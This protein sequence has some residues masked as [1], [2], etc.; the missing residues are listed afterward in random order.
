[1]WLDGRAARRSF[2]SAP[3]RP[4][5]PAGREA[6][7]VPA[8]AFCAVACK[9]CKLR[10]R[11]LPPD[12]SFVHTGRRDGFAR[13]GLRNGPYL[14][15][16]HAGWT[17]LTSRVGRRATNW[18]PRPKNLGGVAVAGGRRVSEGGMPFLSAVCRCRSGLRRKTDDC[19]FVQCLQTRWRYAGYWH[20]ALVPLLERRWI[21]RPK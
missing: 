5:C 2:R 16:E 13:C 12:P 4:V 1:M 20:G 15:W 18:H 14:R 6:K 10:T 19:V 7:R 3:C 9:V 21:F 8:I 11:W 17:G